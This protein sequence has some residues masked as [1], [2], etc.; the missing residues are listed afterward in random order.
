[1]DQYFHPSL[2]STCNNLSMLGLK[3]NYAGKIT[4]LF[5]EVTVALDKFEYVRRAHGVIVMPLWRQN[6]V[7]TSL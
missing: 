7:A 1:M 2:N 4:T 3:L 6:D 5:F